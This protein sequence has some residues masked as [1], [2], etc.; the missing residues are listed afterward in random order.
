M[1]TL[2][3]TERKLLIV[4]CGIYFLIF[5]FITSTVQAWAPV[6]ELDK[7]ILQKYGYST[8]TCEQVIEAT[9]SESYAVRFMALE[10]LTDYI[11][12]EAAPVLNQALSD[13]HLK[14]RITA[15]H[16]L[17][18]LGDNS[19]LEQMRTDF[20]EQAAKA[21][22]P[23]PTDPNIDPDTR[24]RIENER[25]VALYDALEVAKVLAELGDRRGYRLAARMALEGPCT[26][27]R[28]EAARVLVEIAKSETSILSAE[29]IDPISTL[30]KMAESEKDP[31]IFKILIWSVSKLDDDKKVHILEKAKNSPSQPESVRREA[32][33]SLDAIEARKK[34]EKNKPKDSG[35]CCD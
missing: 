25:K 9:K 22:A 3:T 2:F 12:K 19:G 18:T 20:E 28:T 7:M 27:H 1:E 10:L 13:S 34:A 24:E 23:L 21:A 11:G 15:A 26:Y 35:G 4:V 17:G 33:L 29:G 14:V 8:D 5:A 32:Q 6:T 31:N 30:C 16:L